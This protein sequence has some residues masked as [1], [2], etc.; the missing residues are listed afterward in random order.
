MCNLKRNS[1]LQINKILKKSLKKRK[2]I[3]F[4]KLKY[5]NYLLKKKENIK[6]ENKNENLFKQTPEFLVQKKKNI[7]NKQNSD[8]FVKLIMCK[9]FIFLERF[10]KNKKLM[11]FKQ[12]FFYYQKNLKKKKMNLQK[13]I[14]FSLLKMI[15]KEKKCVYFNLFF[16]GLKI[17]KLEIEKKHIFQKNLIKMNCSIKK[18]ITK[19][20]SK[21]FDYLIFLK[22]E[23]FSKQKNIFK[24]LKYSFN[25]KK[26]DFICIL[27]NLKKKSK[28]Q[29]F[30][31]N[32]FE[33]YHLRKKKLVFKDL[34]FIKTKIKIA[35]KKI[36][37]IE[38]IFYKNLNFIIKPKI[39][40]KLKFY[41]LRT[42]IRKKEKIIYSKSYSLKRRKNSKSYK[43]NILI[44][45]EKNLLTNK[46]K[47][48]KNKFFSQNFKNTKKTK[49]NKEKI[50]FSF[51]KKFDTN[52]SNKKEKIILKEKKE[53]INFN[54]YKEKINFN[55][56]KEK[57]ISKTNIVFKK[58]KPDKKTENFKSKKKNSEKIFYRKKL[59]IKKLSKT[60]SFIKFL[61]NDNFE[62]FKLKNFYL[63]ISKNLKKNNSVL[64]KK[65]KFR[66][67][68][69]NGLLN[70]IEDRSTLNNRLSVHL[71][72]NIYKK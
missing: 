6:I 40:E 9:N 11:H 43:K 60:K 2:I 8:F 69:E 21:T 72:K 47:Y 12:F 68:V 26:R 44:N 45:I 55:K 13:K 62:F 7:I 1:S 37:K 49:E 50:D 64:N 23:N 25:N 46:K 29:L 22:I 33:I 32:I 58:K 39:F 38:N 17:K 28:N 41:R 54:K 19:Q 65:V 14:G 56:S 30:L 18:L 35:K 52:F 36:K 27:K 3:F 34:L 57:R 70:T 66:G 4:E 20:K 59:I 5:K 31:K 16:K 42:N 10:V 67:N 24:L 48:N 71:M 63:K 53:K 61:P 15:F 51:E